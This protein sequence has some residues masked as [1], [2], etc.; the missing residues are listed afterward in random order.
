MSAADGDAVSLLTRQQVEE[1]CAISRSQI[2]KRMELG[3]FP[4]PVY[5]GAAAR[6]RSDE[7]T[8]GEGDELNKLRQENRELCRA[9]ESQPPGCSVA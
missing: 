5:V 9:N 7:I 6:W 4:R 8:D 1:R 3:E 2:C